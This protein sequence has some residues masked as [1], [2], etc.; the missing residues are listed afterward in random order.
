MAYEW[1]Q[2]FEDGETRA[3]CS[4]CGVPY[5]YP[6]E[7]VRLN[8]G[9]FYCKRRCL[10]QTVLTRDRIQAQ[11]RRRREQ[12]PPKFV[13]PPTY[14]D[15][16]IGAEDFIFRV[17]L[18]AV[19]S[20]DPADLGWAANYLADVVTEGRRPVRW[21]SE[22][23][24][25]LATICTSLLALQYGA[26]SGPQPTI[27]SE[28]VRYGGFASGSYLYTSIAVIAGAALT[29]AYTLLGTSVYLDGA[30]RCAHF[31]R[32]MQCQ[33]LDNNSQAS[34]YG[35]ANYHVG[36]FAEGVGT[37][38]TI[39]WVYRYRLSDVLGIWFLTLLAGVRGGS[40]QYGGVAGTDF[41]ASTAASLDTMIAEAKA[42]ATTGAKDTASGGALTAGLSTAYPRS[43]YLAQI[44][45]QT[46]LG[47][48][49][50]ATAASGTPVSVLPAIDFAMA[51][52]AL[53]YVGGAID[54][55]NSIYDWLMAFGSNA[56][57]IPP[58]EDPELLIGNLKGTY[59]PAYSPAR[60]LDVLDDDGT[61]ALQREHVGAGLQWA[62]AS[63]LAPISSSRT[64]TAFRAAKDQLSVLQP[65]KR[66]EAPQYRSINESGFSGLTFQWS[67]T[68]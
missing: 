50:L 45:G 53:N 7:L 62:C 34:Q 14:Q 39:S 13:Q 37:S 43:S 32:H 66:G 19:S 10:E 58:P 31:L 8:D 49:E 22:S 1:L 29:K 60:Y 4:K 27:T 40:T 16:Y 24:T 9:F 5:R 61:T 47:T 56:S 6:S 41:T 44:P 59:S 30:D 65:S 18:S 26:P 55:V 12:P 23:R 52:F 33:D 54:Q 20:T 15:D 21:I 38:S 35:G 42:F 25:A 3:V 36:G 2:T 67:T 28:K 57:N 51:L 46:A 48:W 64:P 63:L 17:A 11:S 68:A